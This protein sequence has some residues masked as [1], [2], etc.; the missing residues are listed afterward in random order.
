M[1]KVAPLISPR[2]RGYLAIVLAIAH[3]C[4]QANCVYYAALDDG[5]DLQEWEDLEEW[6]L[7]GILMGVKFHLNNPQATAEDSHNKRCAVLRAQGWKYAPQRSDEDK[8]HP[9]LVSFD[10]LTERQIEKNRMFVEVVHCLGAV[11]GR[12]AQIP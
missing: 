12:Y 4:H 9:C 8:T 2:V 6:K 3:A 11:Y 5:G 7:N 10:Q 1:E